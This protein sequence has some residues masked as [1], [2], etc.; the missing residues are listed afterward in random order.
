MAEWFIKNSD[1]GGAPERGPYRPNELLELVRSGEVGPETN[2]RKD[3]SP[4]FRASDVGGLFEAAMRPTIH[5]YCPHC[6]AAVA[7][8]P[9]T[10][11]KCDA[12]LTRTREEIQE[13]SIVSQD[14]R[15]RS[16]GGQSVQDWLRRKVGKKK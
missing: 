7:E 6:S 9:C 14:D 4:W 15:G 8:P 1:S 13:N 2:I 5:H 12:N 16:S 10:C 11:P 3:N